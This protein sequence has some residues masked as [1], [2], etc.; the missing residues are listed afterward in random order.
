MSPPG[1][2]KAWQKH[3]A[4]PLLSMASPCS[5]DSQQNHISGATHRAGGVTGTQLPSASVVPVP[6]RRWL[7]G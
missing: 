3:I 5:P 1:E 2:S 4:V 7:L 6:R